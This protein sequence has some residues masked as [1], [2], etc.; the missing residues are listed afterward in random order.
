MVNKFNIVHEKNYALLIGR[1]RV[2]SHV[3]REQSLHK[4]KVAT[5]V[6]IT[7]SARILSEFR[8]S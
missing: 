1:K 2:H 6:Q 3:T 4:C 8:I 5:R 7:Y